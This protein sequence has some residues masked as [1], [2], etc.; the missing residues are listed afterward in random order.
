MDDDAQRM[1]GINL[2]AKGYKIVYENILF[3]I[4]EAWRLWTLT[5]GVTIHNFMKRI[6]SNDAK[7]LILVFLDC[8][9]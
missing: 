4:F 1:L 8:S 6:S 7:I 9:P 5:D 2:T 3:I